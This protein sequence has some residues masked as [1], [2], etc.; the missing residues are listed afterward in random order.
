MLCSCL[1]ASRSSAF[2]ALYCHPPPP[3]RCARGALS[4]LVLP[5]CAALPSDVLWCRVAVFCAACCAVVPRLA[6]LWAG[7][8]CAVSVGA[9]VCCA[10]LLIVAAYRAVRLGRSRCALLSGFGLRCCVLCCAVCPWVWCSAALL[11]IVPPGVVVLCAVLVCFARWMPLLVVPCPLSLAVALESCAMRRCV[12]RCS[13]ALC[14]LCCVCFVLAFWCLLLFRA[15]VCAVCVLGCRTVPS[16]SSRPCAVLCCAVLVRLRCAIHVVRAVAGAW[17]CGA[18]LCVRAVSFGILWC[19]AGSGGPWLSSGSVFRC[20]CP[21]LAASPASLCSVRFA[22][23]PCFP[24]SCPVVLCCGLVLC[25]RALLLF[26]GA[27]C[28]RFALLWPVVRRRALP[29]CAAG[30]PCC[31]LPGGGVCVLCCPLAPCRH[32]E[33]TLMT[34]L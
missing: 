6:V 2:L 9:F 20:R 1:L 32:A 14:A 26:C 18:L 4:C 19:D 7:A 30:C 5:R 27:V 8:S 15:V 28:A 25:C 3:P 29:C 33:T 23:V 16:L 34:T 31:F 12:L 21:C 24:V 17:F 10:V 22:V 11:R 13:I